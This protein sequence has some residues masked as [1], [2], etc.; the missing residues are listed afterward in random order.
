MRNFA[1]VPPTVWQT[2]IRKLRRDPEA[3]AIYFHLLTSPHS[4]MIGIYSLDLEYL[5]ID[6]GCPIEG[7]S[8]GLRRVC[9]VGLASYDEE[10]AIVWVHDMA[11]SQI[12][13]RLSPKDKRVVA[14]AKHLSM[15]PICLITIRFY[16]R[17]RE[18][19]HLSQE[20]ILEDFER[21]FRSPIDAPSM[22][23]R[24]KEKDKEQDKDLGEEKDQFRSGDIEL[25]STR[26]SEDPYDPC[27][28]IEE[29][30]RLLIR[31]GVPSS[32]ME[33]GLQ[34]LMRGKLFP[35]DV[36]EWKQEAREERAA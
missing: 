25:G 18:I 30:K 15:L 16:E 27:T 23:L 31:L 3:I 34:R 33:T 36:D 7:A 21:A 9:E 13:P 10:N 19:F 22:P 8:K 35:C 11:M 1:A 28:T 20:V 5:A 26:A 6:L 2:D 14:V 12:A 24:S 17:Y 29:G 32:K 4:S